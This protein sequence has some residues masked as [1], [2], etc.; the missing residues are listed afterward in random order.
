MFL[1]KV[2]AMEDAQPAPTAVAEPV[3]TTEPAAA[4]SKP[5]DAAAGTATTKPASSDWPRPPRFVDADL[6]TLARV[7]LNGRQ[8]KNCVRT[9][10][11]IAVNEGVQLCMEHIRRVLDVTESFDR[12]LK[13]GT[14]YVDAMRSYT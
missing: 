9:A 6:A 4:A 2:R 1:E 8:I 3:T 14:G 11:A 7:S 13:G 10:Q 12:D 5:D